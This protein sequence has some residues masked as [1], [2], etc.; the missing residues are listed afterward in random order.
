MDT[1]VLVTFVHL[2]IK[3]SIQIFQSHFSSEARSHARVVSMPQLLWWQH[4]SRQHISWKQLSISAISQLLLTR[5][6]P[7]F[8]GKFLGQ[9]LQD[10]NCY[11]DD[12][13]PGNIYP[14]NDCPYQQCLSCYWANLNHLFV[15]NFWGSWFFIDNNFFYQTSAD[16]NIFWA[17]NFL[18]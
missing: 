1:F 13:C 3:F 17:K 18:P 12:I 6:W 14:G 7:N 15:P 9:F 4:L 16:Q 5:F 2:I 10:S 11:G 8:K